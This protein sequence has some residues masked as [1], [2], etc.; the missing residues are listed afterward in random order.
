MMTDMNKYQDTIEQLK[1]Q[2]MPLDD[3]VALC[4][5]ALEAI[6]P[7]RMP[8]GYDRCRWCGA[9]WQ[10]AAEPGHYSCCLCQRALK[11]AKGE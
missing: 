7:K 10:L 8:D 5:Q 2:I 11:A 6:T 3:I 9:E 1:A 4:V